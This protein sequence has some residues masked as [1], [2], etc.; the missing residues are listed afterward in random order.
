MY[1]T[2]VIYPLSSIQGGKARYFILANPMTPIIETFRA[3]FLGTGTFDPGHLAYSFS[4]TAIV[5]LVGILIFTKV[6]T[7]FMDTV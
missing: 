7:T 3:G 4:F 2:P 6:E 1:T 5:L